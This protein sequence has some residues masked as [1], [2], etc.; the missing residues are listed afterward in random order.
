MEMIRNIIFAVLFFL[1]GGSAAWV[2]RGEYDKYF[3]L[4]GRFHVVSHANQDY[5]VILEF[6]SG[7]DVEFELKQNGTFDFVMPETGEGA[8]LVIIDGDVHDSIGYVTSTNSLI[9]LTISDNQTTF[10]Q[11]FPSLK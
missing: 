3:M 7:K 10:S 4:E 1:L 9:V 2:A 11:I 5:Q 6:P 8:I